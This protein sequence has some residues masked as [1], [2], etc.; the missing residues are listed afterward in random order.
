MKN[1]APS[2]VSFRTNLTQ[3]LIQYSSSL[4]KKLEKLKLPKP[5]KNKYVLGGILLLIIVLVIVFSTSL[6]KARTDI[7]TYKIQRN[8]F[9]VTITESGELRAKNSLSILAPRIRGNIKIVYLIP[10]GTYVKPGDIVCS[11]DPSEAIATFKGA[12]AAL[13]I[14]NS[15]REKLVA[16]QMAAMAQMESQLKS[17]E[18]SFELSKLKLDQVKFEAQAIQQQS[19]L[20]HEKNRLSFEQTKQEFQSKKI[21]HKSEMDMMVVQIKQRQNDLDKAQKDL[22]QL[23]LKAP[24]EGLVVYGS[25]WSNQGRKFA[26]GD[27][28]WGGAEIATL[29]DLSS[30]ESKTNINEV[31]VS[32][33]SNGKKVIVKLDAFQDSSFVGAVSDVASIGRNKDQESNIK[34]FEVLVSIKAHSEILKPGMTTSNKIIINEI[35]NVLFIP[36]EAVFEKDGK[37]IVYVK[38]GSGYDLREVDLG[39]K[40]EDY[41]VVRKGVASGDEVALLD[42]TIESKNS[43]QASEEKNMAMPGKGK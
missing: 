28:P 42:P 7:P 20:E 39:E 36:Q 40:G 35:P 15:D 9:L 34:V 33:I 14:A 16:N 30:M 25:N 17:A 29:P 18:L 8:N 27:S 6:S 3:K 13:E 41:I 11:F 1:G 12:E 43:T 22:D 5:L 31:D 10:E 19:K 2:A 38:N 21:I 24:S 32:K 26:I 4:D 37:K 23:T